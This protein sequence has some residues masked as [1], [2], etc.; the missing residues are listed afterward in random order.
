V[1]EAG[2]LTTQFIAGSLTTQFIDEKMK[3]LPSLL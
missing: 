2:S 3:T 1:N